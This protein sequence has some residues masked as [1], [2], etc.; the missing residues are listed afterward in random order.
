MQR[1][2]KTFLK[3]DPKVTNQTTINYILEYIS[4]SKID[5]GICCGL[6]PISGFGNSIIFYKNCYLFP[7]V[8]YAEMLLKT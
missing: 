3:T 2:K 8:R 5:F 4:I 6:E 1:R 7:S